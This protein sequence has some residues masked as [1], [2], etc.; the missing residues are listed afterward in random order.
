MNNTPTK[1]LP[2]LGLV[3]GLASAQAAPGAD[4]QIRASLAGVSNLE[5]P[6]KTAGLIA[7]APD[8]NKRAMTINAVQVAVAMNPS[9]AAAIVSAIATRVPSAASVAA[10]TASEL[11]PDQ[12]GQV[13][14]A[15]ASAAPKE[16]GAIV[17]ECSKAAP[18]RS[19]AIA[20]AASKGAPSASH[21]ILVAASSAS[22]AHV[23]DRM[24]A[25][26]N[27]GR[28]IPVDVAV[29]SAYKQGHNGHPDFDERGGKDDRH[30]GHHGNENGHSHG[31]QY[32]GPIWDRPDDWS[33]RH[34]SGCVPGY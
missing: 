30:D 16:A 27:A 10:A 7:A 3:V 11:R 13:A 29:L 8:Q 14:R 34:H 21:E 18:D 12:A 22:P 1:L 9:A 25:A 15:A 32:P 23:R 6:S 2:I 24:V 19:A 26:A 4:P 28:P 17:A 20:V 31:N 33:P 5:L